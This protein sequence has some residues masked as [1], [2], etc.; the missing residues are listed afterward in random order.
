[1]VVAYGVNERDMREVTDDPGFRGVTDFVG[2]VQK[3]GA[4]AVSGELKARFTKLYAER[5]I[6]SG[7]PSRHAGAAICPERT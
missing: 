1:V 7:D 6:R 5:K 3:D 4:A 2:W